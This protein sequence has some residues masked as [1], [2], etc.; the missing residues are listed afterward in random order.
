VVPQGRWGVLVEAADAIVAETPPV[1]GT[2]PPPAPAPNL[3]P[4]RIVVLVNGVESGNLVFE[5]IGSR[6]GIR[7]LSRNGFVSA[8]EIFREAPAWEAA[9]LTLTRGLVNLDILVYDFAGH[10]ATS[11]FRLVVE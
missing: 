11:S 5:T 4:F 9:S 3:S 7:S 8:R 2:R 10:S 1:P 6:E